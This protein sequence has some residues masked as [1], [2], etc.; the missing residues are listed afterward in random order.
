[1]NIYLL[2]GLFAVLPLPMFGSFPPPDPAPPLGIRGALD[3]AERYAEKSEWAE[4]AYPSKVVLGRDPDGAFWMVWLASP[5]RAFKIL[6]VKMDG[7]VTIADRKRIQQLFPDRVSPDK[8]VRKLDAVRD[9]SIP[10][11]RPASWEGPVLSEP[12]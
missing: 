10:W 1:M 9:P 4:D 11:S 3:A 12:T 2:L 5:T 7:K 8:E 6:E